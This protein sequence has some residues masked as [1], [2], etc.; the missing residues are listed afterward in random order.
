MFELIC[1]VGFVMIV[2]GAFAVFA[3][4]NFA[5]FVAGT[6]AFIAGVG[7]VLC[8]ATYEQG[9]PANNIASGEYKVAFIYPAG[10]NI[11]VGLEIKKEGKEHLY[12]Y[13][14]PKSAFE[15]SIPTN[16]KKLTVTESGDNFKKL[17]LGVW[18]QS[19]KVGL[20]H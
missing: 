8:V 3:G 20:S 15:G 16:A 4:D 14:F 18:S 7:L 2:M 19:E 6:M 1:V 5:T 17:E 9:S 10:D 13:Q 12:L 11:A